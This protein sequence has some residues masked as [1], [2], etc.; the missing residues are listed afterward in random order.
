M[1]LRSLSTLLL[2]TTLTA[3]GG[4][5]GGSGPSCTSSSE[6]AQGSFCDFADGTCGSGGSGSCE[7]IPTVCTAE[8]IPVC[9]CEKISFSNECFANAAAQSVATMG[10]CPN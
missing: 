8:V 2:A 1:L 10:N 9:S 5:G 3:C 7:P 4:G 6:C